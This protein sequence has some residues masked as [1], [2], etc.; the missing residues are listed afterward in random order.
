MSNGATFSFPAVGNDITENDISKCQLRVTVDFKRHFP[1]GDSELTFIFQGS[2]Y[3][4]KF[5]YRVDR[6]HILKLGQPLMNKLGLK[7]HGAVE[8]TR[9]REKTYEIFLKK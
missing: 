5:R 4:V 3:P 7:P 1:N 6:S 9:L 2:E 8:I